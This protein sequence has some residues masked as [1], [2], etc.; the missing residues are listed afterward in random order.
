M[1]YV[2]AGVGW[3]DRFQSLLQGPVLDQLIDEVGHGVLLAGRYNQLVGNIRS[4]IGAL[5]RPSAIAGNFSQI[6]E[7]ERAASVGSCRA[8]CATAAEASSNWNNGVAFRLS[9]TLVRASGS[10]AANNNSRKRGRSGCGCFNPIAIDV[11]KACN[12]LHTD[13]VV[14]GEHAG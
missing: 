5:H 4:D 6:A 9:G 10:R 1:G 2:A 13:S 7:L 3:V 14:E 8:G 11:Q 12:E